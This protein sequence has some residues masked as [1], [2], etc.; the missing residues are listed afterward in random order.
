MLDLL[1]R[2]NERS[3]TKASAH[4]HCDQLCSFMYRR[5]HGLIRVGVKLL[6]KADRPRSLGRRGGRRYPE[7]L[8]T[9]DVGPWG[10]APRQSTL[11]PR[12]LVFIDETSATTNV[13]RAMDGENLPSGSLGHAP[14]LED[15][16]FHHSLAPQSRY[17]AAA[18]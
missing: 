14:P 18:A 6:P 3:I 11:D 16:D 8:F 5:R 13:T 12:R 4:H 2:S 9:P 15:L 1:Y 7:R 10:M 17:C